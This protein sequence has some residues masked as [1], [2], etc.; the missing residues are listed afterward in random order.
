MDSNSVVINIGVKACI[1]KLKVMNTL[2]K[3]AVLPA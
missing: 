2:K 1:I 3:Q